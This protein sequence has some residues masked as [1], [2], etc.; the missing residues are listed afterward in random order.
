[1]EAHMQKPG[2]GAIST[3]LHRINPKC[4]K[5]LPRN[6]YK[7]RSLKATSFAWILRPSIHKW[8]LTELKILYSIG[9]NQSREEEAPEQ[10]ICDDS[11]PNE[12]LIP[13]IYKNSQN[14]PE[15]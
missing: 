5:D 4:T 15:K 11:S 2:T 13:K 10:R 1:M 7:E 14:S 9:K 3:I 8:D 12:G 6:Y